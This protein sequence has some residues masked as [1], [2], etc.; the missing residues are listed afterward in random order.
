MVEY[1]ADFCIGEIKPFE[2]F[3]IPKTIF[4]Y[5]SHGYKPTV[6]Y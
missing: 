2:T 4:N 6:K 3:N 1:T 5:P